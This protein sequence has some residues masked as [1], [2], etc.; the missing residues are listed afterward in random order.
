M[1]TVEVRS[2][3]FSS[4]MFAKKDSCGCMHIFERYEDQNLNLKRQKFD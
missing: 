4:K 1:K 3:V 2:F